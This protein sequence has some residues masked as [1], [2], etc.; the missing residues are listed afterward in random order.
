[1]NHAVIIGIFG[2]LSWPSL[3]PQR[4]GLIR[5]DV[6]DALKCAIAPAIMGDFL[7]Q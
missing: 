1:V 3:T 7:D 2:S 4:A 5:P 6:P